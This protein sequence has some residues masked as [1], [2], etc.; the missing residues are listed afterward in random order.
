M[1]KLTQIFKNIKGE[2]SIIL[3]VEL[4][5]EDGENYIFISHNGSS[6]CRYKVSDIHDIGKSIEFYVSNYLV[7]E[8]E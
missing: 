1:T 4:Y 7:G 5:Q 2:K 6:G 8:E 3:D